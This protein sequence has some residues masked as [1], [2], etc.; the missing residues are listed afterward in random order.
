MEHA[1]VKRNIKNNGV[2]YTPEYLVTTVLDSVGYKGKIILKK[3]IIDNSCGDGAF[4]VLVVDRYITEFFK[5]SK[6][7]RIL[8][9]ELTKYVHG[10]ELNISEVEKCKDRLSKVAATHGVFNIH[11]DVKQGNTLECSQFNRTMDFVVGNPPYVRI[12]NL[13]TNYS[14]VKSG[15]FSKKGMTDL[16]I[17]FYEIGIQMLNNMGTLGYITPSSILNSKAGKA[18]RK[19]IIENTMIK[20][21][22]DLRH[23]QAFENFTTYTAIIILD[24]KNI[25]QEISYSIINGANEKP[26][27]IDNLSYDSFNIDDCFYLGTN[28]DLNNLK[29]ILRPKNTKN[30]FSVKNGFATLADW[31]F[32]KEKIDFFSSYTHRCLKGSNGK[33]YEIIFP[34]DKQGKILDFEKIEPELVKY[35]KTNENKLKNRSLEKESKWYG[36]GRSQAIKDMYSSKIALN[37]LVRTKN[38]LKINS[39]KS[40]EGIFS[41]LYI[42]GNISLEKVIHILKN[43]SFI[44]YV[45][46]LG[47][48]KSGGY[49][50]FSSS[51]IKKY[52]SFCLEVEE[53]Q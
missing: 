49:Y 51:D 25:S 1:I 44:K 11:W 14:S 52:I 13:N 34:Y 41:G 12:H 37:T 21:I 40:G 27:F 7:V 29:T 45:S 48:Y 38:D 33:W 39:V 24:K 26:T 3:H 4:L 10:I 35:F 15:N 2:V 23:F 42:I 6:D 32:I 46:M 17:V 30:D 36:F 18:F 20:E 9:D 53:K 19:H 28:S 22:I 47:K 31:F 5:K 43:D 50:T 8:K 16:F